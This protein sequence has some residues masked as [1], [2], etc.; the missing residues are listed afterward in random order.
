MA[1]DS[2]K[3]T[4][5]EKRKYIR[6]ET[7]NV[8]MCEMYS[9]PENQDGHATEFTSKN[10]SAGGILFEVNDQYA[11]GDLLRLEM[12]LPGWNKY[13]PEFYKEDSLSV[14]E[15]LVCLGAVVRVEKLSNGKYDIGVCLSGIDD[16]H[17]MALK[18]YISAKAKTGDS[19]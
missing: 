3:N 8:V 7:Q 1:E 4:V 19:A 9:I 14:D 13:K 11:I 12:D 17:Q 16:G 2:Q 15:P 10:I 18:K 5:S 6:L